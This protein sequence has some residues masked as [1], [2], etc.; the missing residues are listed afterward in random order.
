M[1]RSKVFDLATRRL[2][3][4]HLS[5]PCRSSVV[6]INIYSNALFDVALQIPIL[7]ILES[8]R[9]IVFPVGGLTSP[10]DHVHRAESHPLACLHRL[11]VSLDMARRV[12][13]TSSDRLS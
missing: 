13:L 7:I 1:Q 12:E 3:S 6:F 9:D 11:G 2:P 10:V 5:F 8:P 4:S